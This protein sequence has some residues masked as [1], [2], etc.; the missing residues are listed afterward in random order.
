M[1]Q[2]E[3]LDLRCFRSSDMRTVGCRAE[4]ARQSVGREVCIADHSIPIGFVQ[5]DALGHI[6][7]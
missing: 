2:G 1:F 3:V 6:G 4:V 5:S 7:H